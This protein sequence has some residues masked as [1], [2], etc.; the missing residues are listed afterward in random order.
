MSGDI[1]IGTEAIEDLFQQI[2]NEALAL[3]G[4]DLGGK[5][6][7][8]AEIEPGVIATDLLYINRR[9]QV[10]LVLGPDHLGDLTYELWKQMKD[11]PGWQAWRVMT[12]MVEADLKN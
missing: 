12:F 2:G 9:G 1:A 5:F 8:F 3:A 10:Q 7:V 4:D 6:M 11:H